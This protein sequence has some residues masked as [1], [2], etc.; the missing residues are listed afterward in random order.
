[1]T[2]ASMT[3]E[4]IGNEFHENLVLE[5]VERLA[6][7]S[8]SPFSLAINWKP[9]REKTHFLVVKKYEMGNIEEKPA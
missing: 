3:S 1:M 9:L 4:K 2:F 6:H 8:I 7:P 5:R